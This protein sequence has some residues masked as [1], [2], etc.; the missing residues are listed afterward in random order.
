[1][2]IGEY[3]SDMA[4]GRYSFFAPS[5]C[6]DV[7]VTSTGNLKLWP[8]FAIHGFGKASRRSLI[9]DDRVCGVDAGGVASL[10]CDIVSPSS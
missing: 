6:A 4:K 1:M 5:T 7:R 2:E 8:P 3:L 9:E 10:E